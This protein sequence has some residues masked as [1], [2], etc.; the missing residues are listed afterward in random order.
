[1]RQVD[2][3]RGIGRGRAGPHGSV[4]RGRSYPITLRDLRGPRESRPPD[5][6]V[7]RSVRFAAHG[8]APTR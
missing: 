5:M 6:V 8:A 7:G 2:R 3:T 4:D 1:M